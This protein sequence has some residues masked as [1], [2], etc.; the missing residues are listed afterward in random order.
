MVEASFFLTTSRGQST[1]LELAE[2]RQDWSDPFNHS[3][4]V[5]WPS[6]LQKPLRVALGE[7]K[8]PLFLI[9]DTA[10]TYVIVDAGAD[11]KFL[12]LLLINNDNLILFLVGLRLELGLLSSKRL[13][14]KADPSLF[15]LRYF[16]ALI[17]SVV[18]SL[19]ISCMFHVSQL[20]ALVWIDIG[21]LLGLLVFDSL[22]V[23]RVSL[24]LPNQLVQSIIVVTSNLDIG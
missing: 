13:G 14:L 3:I 6:K 7:K 22:F 18:L 21:A 2:R 23:Y 19:V 17:I 15:N 1:K 10:N 20:V 11:S 8:Q 24:L 9:L 12:F 5:A 4:L 16:S